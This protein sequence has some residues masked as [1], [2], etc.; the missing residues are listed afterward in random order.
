M[1]RQLI[2]VWLPHLG[3]R[4]SP[5]A[6]GVA[7]EQLH[8]SM[9]APAPWSRAK[10]A[11]AL[12]ALLLLFVSGVATFIDP[13]M[14]H[15]I[16]LVRESIAL[17]RIPLEDRFAYTPTVYPVVH[18][19]WAEAAIVYLALTLGGL[20]GLQALKWVL[21]LGIAVGAFELARR[22]GASL[23][24]LTVLTPV[25]IM[26]SWV[27]MTTLRAQV[28]TLLFVVVLLWRTH[29]RRRHGGGPPPMK[30]VPRTRSV[31]DCGS[32]KLRAG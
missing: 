4:G 31:C 10:T 28:F 23:A 20:A 14:F 32:S 30:R 26:M 29:G 9:R 15:G 24:V 18:H 13:D 5:L 12:A 11:L 7:P 25:A 3:A 27:G 19:E 21:T 1:R 2:S 6:G 8:P 22:R 17:G 16:A